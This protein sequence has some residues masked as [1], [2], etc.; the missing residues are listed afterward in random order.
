M[1]VC[2]IKVH[3]IIIVSIKRLVFKC[4]F[5]NAATKIITANIITM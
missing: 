5:Q 2:Y 4:V 1:I 3:L